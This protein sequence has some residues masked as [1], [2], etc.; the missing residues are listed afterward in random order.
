MPSYTSGNEKTK[1]S[2]AF[3]SSSNG[4]KLPVLIIVPRK[5]DLPNFQPPDNVVIIYKSSATFDA[6]TLSDGFLDRILVPHIKHHDLH[7]THL[8]L[9]SA[10]CH[11][12]QSL[13][14]K[15]DEH[16]IKP[17]FI[18]PRFTSLLQP[19]DVVWFA[20]IKKKIHAKWTDWYLNAEKTFTKNNNMRSPGYAT[21]INWISE[22]WS[23]TSEE[24]LSKSFN[25]CG[26]TSRNQMSTVLQTIINKEMMYDYVE[27]ATETDDVELNDF[28][29]F[30]SDQSLP[31]DGDVQKKNCHSCL[32]EHTKKCKAWT[33][34][35]KCGEWY[36]GVCKKKKLKSSF[37]C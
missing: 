36:C 29:V 26:I 22:V 34:C 30:D 13:Q 17:H 20:S 23:Q 19:A 14:D 35:K 2:A 28:E 8:Y 27:E 15:F 25:D 1:L 31:Q 4:K 18:P 5:T 16:H 33:D 10:P 11:K 24:M 32:R 3:C 9:D 37:C 21:L 12:T 7:N 6:T